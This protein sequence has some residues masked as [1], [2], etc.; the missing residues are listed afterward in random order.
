MTRWT[1]VP[2]PERPVCP[3][4]PGFSVAIR[5]H[6][7]PP[8]FGIPSY[9]AQ[10]RQHASNHLLTTATHTELV[11]ACPPL[12]TPGPSP[13]PDGPDGSDH[14]GSSQTAQLTIVTALVTGD[15]HGAQ[16]VVCSV[17]RAADQQPWTAV[18]KI[19]DALYYPSAENFVGWRPRDAPFHADRDYSIEAC[20]YEHLRDHGLAGTGAPAYHGSYTFT[21]PVRR[22]NQPP[23]KRHVRMILMDY[24]DGE[25]LQSL[26]Q[27]GTPLTDA[28]RLDVMAQLL[29]IYARQFHQGISQHGYAQRN[30]IVAP[31]P[32]RAPPT[33]PRV[34]LIDYGRAVVYA[35]S[36]YADCVHPELPLPKN[37][38]LLF[39]DDSMNELIGWAPHWWH[40]DDRRRREWLV[41][42]FVASAS[43]AKYLPVTAELDPETTESSEDDD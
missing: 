23:A 21:V 19:Y 6:V 7:P 31:S 33:L 38:A 18:A 16:V 9:R 28:Y 26:T 25:S 13:H 34:V 35:K 30:F 14:P 5:P 8:P 3:Y 1:P 10:V 15:S 39:W 17:Q 41:E 27:A 22:A 32:R 20:A 37:P 29:D 42:T 2:D 40:H 36:R 43:A 12:D 4:F 24:I 11:L